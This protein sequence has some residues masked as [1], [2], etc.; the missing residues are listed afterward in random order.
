MV[1]DNAILRHIIAKIVLPGGSD[2]QEMMVLER[3]TSFSDRETPE[4]SYWHSNF[5]VDKLSTHPDH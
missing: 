2:C 5:T 1:R 4:Q 3:N